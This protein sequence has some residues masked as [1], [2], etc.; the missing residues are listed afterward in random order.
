MSLSVI[1][2]CAV[3]GAAI[4]AQAETCFACR[5]AESATAARA[6]GGEVAQPEA[7]TRPLLTVRDFA[8]LERHARLEMRPDAPLARDLLALLD[9]ARIVRTDSLPP[10]VAALG[11]HV[12][13]SADEAEP[14]ARI[15]LLP[16]SRAA[17]AWTLPVSSPHGMALLGRRAGAEVTVPGEEGTPPE[18]LRLLTAI[19][20]MPAAPAHA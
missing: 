14:Q 4:A 19:S 8:R 18:R 5:M 20:S 11:S 2:I 10:G 13:F 16:G 9:D 12:I 17:A 3:C 1:S 15:L 6:T 7:C